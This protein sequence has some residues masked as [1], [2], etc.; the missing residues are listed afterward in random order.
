MEKLK[1]IQLSNTRAAERPEVTIVENKQ[2]N[3]VIA[4]PLR[5][6]NPPGGKPAKC[7]CS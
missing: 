3:Y 5:A 6:E 7:I 1:S 2:C 4:A